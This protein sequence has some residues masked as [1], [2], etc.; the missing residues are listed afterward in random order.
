MSIALKEA[1]ET[2]Y[3]LELMISA[4]ILGELEA[5]ASLKEC[6]E[7]SRILSSIIKKC[8]ENN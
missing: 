1:E 6:N 4:G 7:L 3:W 8:N 2:E 5:S